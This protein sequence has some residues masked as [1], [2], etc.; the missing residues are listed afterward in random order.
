[1]GSLHIVFQ[2]C[3][4]QGKVTEGHQPVPV[5]WKVSEEIS[6]NELTL[7]F[8]VTVLSHGPSQEGGTE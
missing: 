1:M 3:N 8:M 4:K 5:P 2:S 6:R 7:E